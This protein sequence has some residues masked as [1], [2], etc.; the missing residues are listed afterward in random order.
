MKLWNVPKQDD[1]FTLIE[2]LAVTVIIGVVGAIA[3]PN[4]IGQINK[5]RINDGVS[6]IEGA[7]REAKRQAT[8]RKQACTIQIGDVGGV[9]TIQ[10]QTGSSCLLETRQLADGI[11][12]ANNTPNATLAIQFSGKGNIG[13]TATYV[14]ASTGNWTI[15]VSH[16]DVDNPKCLVIAGLFGE[17]QTGVSQGGVCVTNLN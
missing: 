17:I 1:G 2:I 9:V 6:Q 15:T 13:N 7:F 16:D 14:P 11:N 10:N 8:S 12:I 3:A 5:S 4:V